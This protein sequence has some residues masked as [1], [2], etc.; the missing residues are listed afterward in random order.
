MNYQLYILC[1]LPF[2]GKTTLAKKLVAKLGFIRIDLDEVKF[3]LFGQ[4]IKDDQID[5]SGW[6]RVYQAMY[7]NIKTALLKGDTVIHDTGNFTK[8]ER[9][10][11]KKIADDLNLKPLT[12]FVNTPLAVAKNRW[13]KNKITKKRFDIA[14]A[15][16]ADCARELEPPAPSEPHLVFNYNDSVDDWINKN[17]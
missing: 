9:D 15:S 17:F 1:G 16:F 13:L 3:E 6:D 8:S 5:Q 14:E 4:G 2:S 11:V 10:L 12:I 7:Q